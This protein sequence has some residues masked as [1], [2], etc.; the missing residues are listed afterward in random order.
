MLK[1]LGIHDLLNFDFMDPP[2]A[3]TLLRALE[4]LYALGALNDKGELTKL[5]RTHGGV[6]C[7]PQMSKMVVASD[8]FL[9][10]EEIVTI[11]A[12]LS[13]G[14][15]VST[16]P[17][18]RQVHADNARMNFHLGGVGDHL[19]LLRVSTTAGPSRLLHPVLLRRTT[20]RFGA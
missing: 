20:S 8:Q 4:M 16:G 14:R 1:S 13:V 10:P 3:E 6:P 9:L 5:G 7:D 15:R 12:M 18:T 19:A 2:P 11:C 17:R